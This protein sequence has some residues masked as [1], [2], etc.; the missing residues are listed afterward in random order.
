MSSFNWIGTVPACANE[1]TLTT[2]L[3]NEWGFQGMVITD[4]D[5]SYGY[6]ITA[7]VQEM[8]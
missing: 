1:D 5:G 6:M 2:I 4:Y 8:T 3:R 7:F